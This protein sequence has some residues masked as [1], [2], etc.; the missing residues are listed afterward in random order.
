MSQA[1]GFGSSGGGGGGNVTGPGSS[2]DRAIATWN[3]TSGDALY[4]N[5]TAK[6][7]A[8]GIFTN[9]AQPEFYVY[10]NGS[11]SNVTG[12]GTQYRIIFDGVGQDTTSSYNASTGIYTIPVTGTYT[13]TAVADLSNLDDTFIQGQ[14]LIATTQPNL[15]GFQGNFGAMRNGGGAQPFFQCPAQGTYRYT[16]GD[17]AYVLADVDGGTKTVGLNGAGFTFFCGTMTA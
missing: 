14:I 4:D 9:S 5:P 2:T 8:A 11:V 12:D 17:Q 16:A 1:S 13:F 10:L 7:T 3:G 6:I 15:Y